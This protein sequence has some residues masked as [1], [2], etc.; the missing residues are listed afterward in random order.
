MRWGLLPLLAAVFLLT[1]CHELWGG[2]ASSSSG[3]YTSTLGYASAA[4]IEAA[5]ANVRASIPAIEAWH[6]DHG[7]YAGLTLDDLEQQYHGGVKD[8]LFVGPLNRKTYC[9]ESTVGQ[10]T[11]HKQ[12]PGAE[13]WEGHCG[14][15]G[16]PATPPPPPSSDPQTT[17]RTAI[18]AI[19]AWYADHGTYEGITV[20]KL[21]TQYDY[22][23][24]LDLQIV[25]A[26]RKSY[27][28]E[29]TVAGET[30]SYVGPARGFAPGSC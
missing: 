4:D 1:G 19:E 23:I 28:A 7:T 24:S 9:V 12:G 3:S 5:Q 25:R 6:A 26:T 2:S 16:T 14:H 15:K 17:L 22:G 29:S 13:V 10:T 11:F 20:N 8:V 18:P 21:R 30:W 27:C